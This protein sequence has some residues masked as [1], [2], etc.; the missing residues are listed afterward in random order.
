MGAAKS[1]NQGWNRFHQDLITY[2][3]P[4]KCLMQHPQPLCADAL[5]IL[6]H[7]PPG[8]MTCKINSKLTQTVKGCFVTTYHFIADACYVY[9]VPLWCLERC[10]IFVFINLL[11]RKPNWV[12]RIFLDLALSLKE[13]QLRFLVINSKNLICPYQTIHYH[14]LAGVVSAPSCVSLKTFSFVIK[15]VIDCKRPT[16]RNNRLHTQPLWTPLEMN[17]V[18]CFLRVQGCQK[19]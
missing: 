16:C 11:S 3:H 15:S 14:F 4:F 19:F 9:W 2:R 12:S 1:A 13:I 10:M 5:A 18:W 7:T 6:W 8:W 17:T